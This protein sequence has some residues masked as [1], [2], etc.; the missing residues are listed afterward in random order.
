MAKTRHGVAVVGCGTVGG[1][2]GALL[3]KNAEILS[4]RC[5]CELQL[6]A[7][8]SRTFSRADEFG[9]PSSLRTTE[10]RAVLEDPDVTV[11]VETVGGL[12]AAREIVEQAIDAGKHVVTANK[13]LLAE[14]GPQLYERARER[15]VSI[16]FEASCA[17]GI[18]VVRALYDG[19]VANEIEAIYGIVNGTSNYILTRMVDAGIAYRDALAEAQA[20]GYAEADPTLDVDGTD[21][22]HKL[23]IL[24]SL[25]FGIQ[26]RTDDVH[27][28]G[29]DT[30]NTVDVAYASRL[31][32]VVKL[33]AIA[34]RQRGGVSLLVRPAFISRE[35]P[36]A[37][38]SGPFNAVSIYG[39]VTGHTMYYGRGAGGA[40]TAGAVISDIVSV[41]R[42]T[43]PIVFSGR[44]SLGAPAT[45]DALH[46]LSPDRLRNRYYLRLDV[47]D[48]PGT[49]A[50]IAAVFAE[51]E[52]SIASVL[53]TEAPE[54]AV[55]SVVPVVITLHRTEEGRLAEPLKRIEEL[56]AVSGSVRPIT[57]VD[58]HP[59]AEFDICS[60]G[61]G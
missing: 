24:A 27:I 35:H 29:I 5:G 38:V 3:L 20:E 33:L 41:A 8:V 34:R 25:A 2:T 45:G 47:R 17:G 39:D 59:E 23:A 26:I 13:A 55:N 60:N 50:R 21:S 22:A 19:L 1:A 7:V 61:G 37:W 11:V 53:Q 57:I 12:E 6:R 28:Q 9:I 42:G 52:I 30:L 54:D 18:P 4:R 10:L 40:P 31:G 32:Y 44:E 46:L 51:Y 48:T 56:D 16:S 43:Y 58:E 14:L 15:S 36:L 49:L